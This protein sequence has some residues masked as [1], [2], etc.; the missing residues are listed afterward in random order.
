MPPQY[1][2]SLV[3]EADISDSSSFFVHNTPPKT[4][5][6]RDKRFRLCMAANE[7]HPIPH[8]D[9]MT[10]EEVQDIWYERSDYEKMKMS[11][12]PLI[13]KMMKGEHVEENNRQ[14]IRGLEFR[15]REGAIRRQ[16]NKVEAITAVL[17][18]QDRQIQYMGYVDD[19]LLSKIYC[20]VNGHCQV[21]AHQL[22]MGDVEPARQHLAD[23]FSAMEFTDDKS[24][25]ERKKSIGRLI[26]QMRLRRRPTLNEHNRG[27]DRPPVPPTGRQ[28]V[29]SAA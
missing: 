19:E 26:K 9:D 21:E 27:E 4:K 6:P 18:E 10:D 25:P 20:E 15:T 16:H 13:R 2:P 3:Q 5:A 17:D 1:S 7:I 11:M 23:V 12:I 28:I 22:A 29:G 8:I 24:A 14:T